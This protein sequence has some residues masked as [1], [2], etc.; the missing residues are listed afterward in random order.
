MAVKAILSHPT[1]TCLYKIYLCLTLYGIAFCRIFVKIINFKDMSKEKS[2]AKESKKEPTKT[3]KE[4][5]E[6]KKEKKDKKKF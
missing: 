4:K 6:A 3:L 1:T 5:R 2:P